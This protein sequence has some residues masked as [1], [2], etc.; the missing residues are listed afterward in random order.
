MAPADDMRTASMERMLDDGSG[1]RV[2]ARTGAG[3]LDIATMQAANVHRAATAESAVPRLRI[4]L[5]VTHPP[6]LQ[7][8]AGREDRFAPMSTAQQLLQQ[9]VPTE[10]K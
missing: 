2:P 7:T 9:R 8:P 1:E 10:P 3:Q 4:A 6:C 5:T